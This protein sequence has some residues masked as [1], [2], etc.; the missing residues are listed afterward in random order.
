MGASVSEPLDKK[1]TCCGDIARRVGEDGL[2]EEQMEKTLELFEKYGVTDLVTSSPHCFNLFNKEYP[3]LPEKKTFR[4]RRTISKSDHYTQLLED[5]LDRGLI[6]PLKPLDLKV[7]YQ[8]PCYLGRHNNLYEGPRR[9][10]RA[11]PGVK[12]VEMAHSALTASAAA[13]AA[14]ECGRSLKMRKSCQRYESK[15]R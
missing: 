15:K 11:I 14:E 5:L 10:I 13:G 3:R 8:D 6:G 12:L 1:K 4:E 9:I 7:T 2:F